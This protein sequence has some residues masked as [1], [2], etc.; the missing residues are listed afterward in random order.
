MQESLSSK[1]K[2]IGAAAVQRSG[3][4]HGL[5]MKEENINIPNPVQLYSNL[6]LPKKVKLCFIKGSRMK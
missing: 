6:I 4:E 2:S 5:N 3:A 1:D